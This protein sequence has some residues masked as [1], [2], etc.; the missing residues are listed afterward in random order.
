MGVIRGS[1]RGLVKSD[2][3]YS[4]SSAGVSTA[5]AV[6]SAEGSFSS[7]NSD[8]HTVMTPFRTDASALGSYTSSTV[9][10]SGK[11]RFSETP[12]PS[13]T[14]KEQSQTA[15]RDRAAERRNL[16][17]SSSSTGDDLPDH[18]IQNSSKLV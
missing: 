16:Y 5:S 6:G 9:T 14:N 18:E 4:G 12:V 7:T 15:Y 3:P 8:I 17:G 2:T 10:G 1:A 13:T 11:R